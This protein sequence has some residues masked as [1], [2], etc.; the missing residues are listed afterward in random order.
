MPGQADTPEKPADQA[1]FLKKLHPK[2]AE[3]K[4][5]RR[6]V[7][8]LAAA[9]F[10]YGAFLGCRWCLARGFR[11]SPAG[12]QRF[13]VLGAVDAV[14]RRVLDHARYQR[15]ALVQA[16]AQALGIELEF[17]PAYSPNLNL[18][19]RDWRWV[20]KRCLK[21]RYHPDFGSRKAALQQTTTAAHDDYAEEL[22]SWLTWNFQ[23]FPQTQVTK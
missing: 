7:R 15:C 21:A 12:R 19:E 11:R 16:H 8:F 1:A 20:K 2:L 10:G 22:A 14:S 23:T 4:A 17:L 9:H 3:A 5:G 18:I 6:V 13:H